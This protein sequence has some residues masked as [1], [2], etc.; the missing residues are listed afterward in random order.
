[1]A[2][3]A[4]LWLLTA[5]AAHA[6][7]FAN[8]TCIQASLEAPSR[9]V[10]VVRQVSCANYSTC[11]KCGFT[12]ALFT[13]QDQVAKALQDG[14]SALKRLV[15]TLLVGAAAVTIAA[16]R[17]AEAATCLCCVAVV[18]VTAS[19]CSFV[20]T[21]ASS[22]RASMPAG[23][24]VAFVL[25]CVLACHM[26]VSAF[27]WVALAAW[28][29]LLRCFCGAKRNAQAVAAFV[30]FILHLPR[31]V[32]AALVWV[33]SQPVI[34]MAVAHAVKEGVIEYN[35]EEE[36][37]G[38]D[39]NKEMAIA[40]CPMFDSVAPKCLFSVTNPGGSHYGFGAC[41]IHDGR[42]LFQ[43]ALHVLREVHQAHG[44][45]FL[46]RNGKLFSLG[47][48]TVFGFSEQLDYVLFESEKY[49]AQV[50]C[51]ALGLS[52]ARLAKVKV[53][54]AIEVYSPP[55]EGAE[56]NAVRKSCSVVS[57]P[58]AFELAY[59]ASTMKG[60]SG[61]PV[62]QG[63]CVVGVHIQANP[64]KLCNE[65][66]ALFPIVS[67]FKQ[68]ESREAEDNGFHYVDD[69]DE[70]EDLD[71]VHNG[72]LW[73]TRRANQ[74]VA[75]GDFSVYTGSWADVE[76]ETDL[77]GYRRQKYRKG[78]HTRM[79]ES[80]VPDPELPAFQAELG[81]A[82]VESGNGSPAA[83]GE[84]L[85]VKSPSQSELA[86]C[87]VPSFATLLGLEEALSR[88][89]TPEDLRTWVSS[90]ASGLTPG[91]NPHL[92]LLCERLLLTRQQAREN[93][94][95]GQTQTAQ[96]KP[97]ETP[98][99]SKQVEHGQTPARNRRRRPRRKHS[100]QL[101]NGSPGPMPSTSSS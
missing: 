34:E 5:S 91:S 3:V 101:A 56:V 6:D 99:V 4:G 93:L 63:N 30:Q 58:R 73:E 19:T 14:A 10:P 26:A 38:Y 98:C 43:T 94:D 80:A 61:S 96:A 7:G 25:C 29:W 54:S 76:V 9:F 62:L 55:S 37:T 1:M 100:Q 24:D 75:Y 89:K 83:R 68:K 45:V 85:E 67:R 49:R 57:Q 81:Q 18:K 2:L 71:I 95:S 60:S 79:K 13:L 31:S 8:A 48:I 51:S 92:L 16:I 40:G 97:S 77:G 46:A 65:G 70:G 86:V 84:L 23:E 15:R 88:A 41:I 21:A 44:Q 59:K 20:N 11:E 69:L 52:A 82:R 78:A 27:L 39:R 64:G 90:A 87:A 66:V 50:I 47:N 53:G 12:E 74:A 28:R 33:I 32:I 42:V 17:C 36:E 35:F 72:N 22:I